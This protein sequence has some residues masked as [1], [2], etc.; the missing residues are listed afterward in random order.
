ML[1]LWQFISYGWARTLSTGM[2]SDT[3]RLQHLRRSIMALGLSFV[4]AGILVHHLSFLGL[5][6]IL[7]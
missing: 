5:A 2:V 1:L 6:I 4:V 7:L 3:E